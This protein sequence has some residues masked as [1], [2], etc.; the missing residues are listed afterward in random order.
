[1]KAR[2]QSRG[3]E[4]L[5]ALAGEFARDELRPVALQYDESEEFPAELVRRAAELGLTC[6]D[7]PAGYGGGVR[8]RV[9][10]DSIE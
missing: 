5:V 6:Y 9:S 10:I 3:A 1:M 8:F 7:L 4:E 2:A